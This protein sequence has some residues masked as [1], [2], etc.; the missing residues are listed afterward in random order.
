[1]NPLY[2]ERFFFFSYCS[3]G[4]LTWRDG[5][6]DKNEIWIKIGGDHGGNS[7]KIS[8][9]ILNLKEPNSRDHTWCIGIFEAKD[10]HENLRRIFLH[11]EKKIND[12]STSTW[13]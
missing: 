4:N 9:Q 2:T 3:A 5:Q 8:L 1:M 12:L 13:R 11:M 7:M 6:I 10:Y